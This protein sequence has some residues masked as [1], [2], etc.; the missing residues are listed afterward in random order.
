MK[1]L[2]LQNLTHRGTVLAE[3]FLFSREILSE[4]NMRRRILGFAGAVSK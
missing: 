3:G 4:E 2:V 1:A